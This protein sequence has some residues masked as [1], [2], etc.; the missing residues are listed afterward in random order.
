M[1]TGRNSL[2]LL[3]VIAW[4]LWSKLAVGIGIAVGIPII[5]IL[6]LLSGRA[7]LLGS[8][9]LRDY[10]AQVGQDQR[11]RVEISLFDAKDALR[12]LA[13]NLVFNG[14][15]N[16][17]LSNND[18][19]GGG[20]ATV[21]NLLNV[22]LVNTHY[23]EHARLL[24]TNG[25]VVAFSATTGDSGQ[26]DLTARSFVAGRNA[27]SL[28]ETPPLVVYT[29]SA[30]MLAAG[31]NQGFVEIVQVVRT[32]SG[33]VSGYLIGRL[34][35]DRMLVE[36]LVS[37]SG[38]FLT[39]RSYLANPDR[40]TFGDLGMINDIRASAERSPINQAL[41]GQ[42][43][44]S[45]YTVGNTIF[46]G[47]Y[48]PLSDRSLALIVETSDSIVFSLP[49]LGDSV[50]TTI[51]A[52]GGFILLIVVMTSVGVW[53]IASPITEVRQ[54]MERAL[55]GEDMSGELALRA[56]NYQDQTGALARTFLQL[57]TRVT[58]TINGLE[59]RI[60][61]RT[62]DIEATQEVARFAATQRD[63]QKLMD[64][65]VKLIV[66][67]FPNI[68][69][70]QIFLVDT[71]DTYAVLRASTGEAGQKLLARG[72]RL[73]VGSTSVIGQVTEQ[74]RIIV[75]T[76]T[77]ASATHRRN[78]FLPDT[79]SE[80]AIPLSVGDRVIGALDVQS[81]QA[82]TF[83]EDQIK[84]LQTM[85]DQI[86]I[87]LDNARLYEE[88]L[89]QLQDLSVSNRERTFSA[90]QEELYARR[91]RELVAE[92]GN[93]SLNTDDTTELFSLR[94]QAMVSGQA[95]V[96]LLTD[97][98]TIPVAVPIILRNQVLGA[99]EWELP[100]N[101]F[102]YE[103][104]QLAEELVSR[105]ALSLDNARL[106][107]QSQRVI[108]RERVVNN[109]AAKLAGQTNVQEILQIAVREVGQALRAPEVNIQLKLRENRENAAGGTAKPNGSHENGGGGGGGGS[110]K[111]SGV[112]SNGADSTVAKGIHED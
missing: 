28:N 99:V 33:V 78:E 85:A 52:I 53:L 64:E 65:V 5:V 69:H 37:A 40:V 16:R 83:T 44:I 19:T 20:Q 39:T 71:D 90:W 29:P 48:T 100:A 94:R 108:A 7:E 102:S 10:L 41:N 89:R 22:L 84:I 107:E 110:G 67:Q 51:T 36:N 105:L 46:T 104:V 82:N 66:H 62:R 24:N 112:T 32:S 109:I 60:N 11:S 34:N 61:T 103:K 68:Y 80:L 54:A 96:G 1:T 13:E 72:H 97:R 17:V 73:A 43:G 26:N 38:A 76:D 2:R 23:Y 14:Q 87:S 106:F 81:K 15:L 93:P 56:A 88:S 75:A 49:I 74:Q 50:F 79:R 3:N 57:R 45:T 55:S 70:A 98:N 111:N 35:V 4:P 8:V 63:L 77:S 101:D 9:T 47:Y 18:I 92:V 58:D 86:A 91:S 30:E 31:L 42:T 27:S 6:F 21:V 25:E 12:N 59:E 95:S